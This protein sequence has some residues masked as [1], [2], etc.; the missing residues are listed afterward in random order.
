[1]EQFGTLLPASVCC[2][3]E[4]GKEKRGRVKMGENEVSHAVVSGSGLT[5]GFL[6]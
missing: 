6:W 1:M 2:T 5:T 4:K 3:K